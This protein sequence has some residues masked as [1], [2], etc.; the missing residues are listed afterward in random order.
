MS[1]E[2]LQQAIVKIL[3]KK[4]TAEEAK[5]IVEL[6]DKDHDGKVSVM[7]LMDYAKE[8]KK[9]QEVEALE[10]SCIFFFRNT[11]SPRFGSFNN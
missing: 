2:E 4:I 8:R 3:N 5:E 7:E 6:L 10:V 11:A 1:A 9:K